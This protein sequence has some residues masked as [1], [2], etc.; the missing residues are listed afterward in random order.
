MKIAVSASG[1][2]LDALIDPLFGRC[3]YFT[4]VDTEDMSFETFDNERIALTEKA[5]I[6]SVQFVVS[7][8]AKVVITGHCGPNAV[9]ALSEAGVELIV[10]LMG[11]VRQAIDNY[12]KGK[13]LETTKANVEDH[14]GIGEGT[15]VGGISAQDQKVV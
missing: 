1:E 7:K 15:T 4:I 9:Q 6:Q 8:G 12:K 11:S 2:G 5:G 13:L 3:G 14:Y 10:D